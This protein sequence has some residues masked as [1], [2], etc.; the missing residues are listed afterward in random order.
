MVDV[1]RE[2]LI[3][4]N[5][6]AITFDVSRRTIENW[7]EQGLDSVKLGRRVY[8]SLEAFERFAVHRQPKTKRGDEPKNS[9]ADEAAAELQ[10]RYGKPKEQGT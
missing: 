8:T 2:R 4:I 5:K 1:A 10:R 3:P 7:F 9:D 6:A